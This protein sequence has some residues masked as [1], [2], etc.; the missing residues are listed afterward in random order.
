MPGRV[1][2]RIVEEEEV[3][4]V[5]SEVC[6][7]GKRWRTWIEIKMELGSGGWMEWV[8]RE[9]GKWRGKTWSRPRVR[10]GQQQQARWPSL[11][12]LCALTKP[13]ARVE[14]RLAEHPSCVT[15]P[16]EHCVLPGCRAC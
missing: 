5:E 11:D 16:N 10:G 12:V 4:G 3:Y 14:L 15:G 13:P 7:R 8:E 2:T 1:D 6:A 9:G